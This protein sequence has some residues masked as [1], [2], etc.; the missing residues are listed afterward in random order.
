MLSRAPRCHQNH[1]RLSRIE[2]QRE[3]AVQP[4]KRP[5]RGLPATGNSGTNRRR[6]QNG[7][8]LLEIL[9]SPARRQT[10]AARAPEARDEHLG[11]QLIRQTGPPDNGCSSA[12][13][14]G[15]DE[16]ELPIPPR[17]SQT[18]AARAPEAR[19]GRTDAAQEQS[20]PSDNGCSSARSSGPASGKGDIVPSSSQTTAARAPEARDLVLGTTG[21]T[22]GRRQRL[23]ERQKLETLARSRLTRLPESYIQ[24]VDQT[25]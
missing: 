6:S 15:L 12:R 17:L 7:R 19:D 24:S 2:Y 22:A 1:R 16:Q 3:S 20:Q 21:T 4:G 14:S 10:T 13:S 5:P 25:P 11:Y 18:T 23:L 9:S 8:W